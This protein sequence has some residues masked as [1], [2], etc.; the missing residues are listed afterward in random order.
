MDGRDVIAVFSAL[1]KVLVSLGA[2]I[3]LGKG[4]R[5]LQEKLLGALL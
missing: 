4:V 5:V 2:K 3:S 1:E